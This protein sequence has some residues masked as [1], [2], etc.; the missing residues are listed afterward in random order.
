MDDATKCGINRIYKNIVSFELVRVLM[1]IEN[2]ILPFDNKVAA[3]IGSE[4]FFEP[5]I[6]TCPLSL[7]APKTS[8]FC[9]IKL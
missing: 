7:F 1:P 6:F 5:D 2:I 3:K 9:I 4:A 8:S